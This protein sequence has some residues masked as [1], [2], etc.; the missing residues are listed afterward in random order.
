MEVNHLEMEV[1]GW[2]NHRTKC[3]GLWLGRWEI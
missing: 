1:Y 2:D 3:G